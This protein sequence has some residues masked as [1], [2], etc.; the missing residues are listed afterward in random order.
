ME[1]TM[2]K[3]NKG[4]KNMFRTKFIKNIA[5]S[6]LML[7]VAIV[8]YSNNTNAAPEYLSLDPDTKI[9]INQDIRAKEALEL[10]GHFDYII[11]EID[12]QYLA[13][14]LPS[15][16]IDLDNEEFDTDGLIQRSIELSLAD[17]RLRPQAGE[18]KFKLSCSSQ[19][20]FFSC[21]ASYYTFSIVIENIVDSENAPTGEYTTS[22]AALRKVENGRTIA[23]KLDDAYFYSEEELPPEPVY[24]YIEILATSEGDGV[25]PDEVYEY[26]VSVDGPEGVEYDI[27]APENQYVFAGKIRTSDLVLPAGGV[28]KI[29][30]KSG[31]SAKIGYLKS[32]EEQGEEL[33]DGGAMSGNNSILGTSEPAYVAEP[34]EESPPPGQILAGTVYTIEQSTSSSGYTT[35]I[36]SKELGERKAVRQTIGELAEDNIVHFYNYRAKPSVVEKIQEYVNTGIKNGIGEYLVLAAAAVFMI[37]AIMLLR[38][39]LNA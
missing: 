31:E 37:I 5:L 3:S 13:S 12:N 20:E 34:E 14:N 6:V 30:L 25:D 22:F 1:S 35:W 18:Y 7:L 38:K 28:A 4:K 9:I 11:E 29:Y 2:M 23:T 15:G 36:N 32:E 16:S 26:S 17:V 8:P 33:A 24:S 39:G 10:T 21:G 27:T 19:M